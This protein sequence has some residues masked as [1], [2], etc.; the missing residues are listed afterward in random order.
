VN[1]DRSARFLDDRFA[2]SDAEFDAWLDALRADAEARR[3]L[4]EQ[5]AMD[6]VLSRALD[7]DRANFRAQVLYR[8]R[9]AMAGTRAIRERRARI[10]TT[11]RGAA[12]RDRARRV[13]RAAGWLALGAAAAAG[14]MIVAWP[15][16]PSRDVPASDRRAADAPP[17]RRVA[18]APSV[19]EVRGLLAELRRPAA[20]APGTPAPWQT[21]T[22]GIA[23]SAGD[24]V[25]TGKHSEVK[26]VYPDGTAILLREET[27]IEV[28]RAAAAAGTRNDP[29]PGLQ[30]PPLPKSL[31][32]A[33]G[34]L[35]GDVTI[36]T[37]GSPLILLTPHAEARVWGTAFN[38]L[39]VDAF[40][41]CDVREG[42]VQFSSRP[43]GPPVEVRAGQFAA[44]GAGL[45]TRARRS[46]GREISSRHGGVF[47]QDYAALYETGR[48]ALDAPTWRAGRAIRRFES[49]DLLKIARTE[50]KAGLAPDRDGKPILRVVN[51]NDPPGQVRFELPAPPEDA[52]MAAIDFTIFI[53]DLK[54]LK[55]LRVESDE[56]M[57]RF[58]P[59]GLQA[60][61]PATPTNEIIV[62]ADN[63]WAQWYLLVGRSPRGEPIYERSNAV[64]GNVFTRHWTIGEF[65]PLLVS[66]GRC[67]MRFRS[68]T[69]FEWTRREK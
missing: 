18:D 25:R 9:D 4:Q 37:P 11:I 42:L 53:S 13:R 6:D 15:T 61:S 39:V 52:F 35:V 64:N 55:P 58:R 62:G 17:A 14:L 46:D 49:D 67:E 28:R 33:R 21:V 48:F 2:L 50:L 23:L 65:G 68:I 57:D 8:V 44:A 36:Q 66:F 31:A 16:R 59:P 24:E 69:L 54:P 41:R 26:L 22:P 63:R 7:P 32:I 38:L 30:D 29:M 20:A 27:S 10:L 47:F 45:E 60:W 34:A 56:R 43:A 51:P 1:D 19:V 12:G 3:A 5:L 40:S